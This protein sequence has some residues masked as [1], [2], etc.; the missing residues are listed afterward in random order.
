MEKQNFTYLEI[1]KSV[2]I[3]QEVIPWMLGKMRVVGS[4]S[5]PRGMLT[6]A[7]VIKSAAVHPRRKA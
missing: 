5:E 1:Y 2:R 7:S 3:V 4:P 6:S